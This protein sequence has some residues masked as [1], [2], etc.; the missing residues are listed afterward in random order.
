[1]ADPERPI[2]PPEYSGPVRV[3]FTTRS[4]ATV[5]FDHNPSD[6]EIEKAARDAE[7]WPDLDGYDVD[8]EELT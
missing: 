3:T 8:V 7:W 1:M 6:E 2:N 5:D 4:F